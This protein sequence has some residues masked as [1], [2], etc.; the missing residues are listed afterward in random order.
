MGIQKISEEKHK[1]LAVWAA[2][3]AGHVLSLYEKEY[4]EDKRPRKAIEAARAWAKEEIKAGEAR[5]SALA[6]HAAAREAK[7]PEAIA[8]ARAAGHAAATTHVYSHAKHAASYAIKAALD[9]KK[10]KDWQLRRFLIY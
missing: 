6:A 3:C 1:F 5:K 4:P 9:A 8:A 7:I 2:D 10:E